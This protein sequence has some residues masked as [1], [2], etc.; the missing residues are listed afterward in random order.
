MKP[1]RFFQKKW[2]DPNQSVGPFTFRLMAIES[3]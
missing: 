2:A 1:H 3:K